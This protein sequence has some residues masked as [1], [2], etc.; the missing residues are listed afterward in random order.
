[1][2]LYIIKHTVDE[3]ELCNLE[4]KCLFKVSTDKNYFFV[5]DYIHVDRSPFV[6]FCIKDIIIHDSKEDL[7][8]YLISTNATYDGFKVKYMDIQGD[9]EFEKRHII[10]G[11]IGY[12]INGRVEVGNPSIVLGV[13]KLDGKWIFGQLEKN[14]GVW[15]IHMGR[16]QSY[17]NA[18]TTKTARAI[19]NISAQNNMELKIVDPCCGIGTVVMEAVSMGFDVKGYDI[20]EN[21]VAGAQKNLKFFKYPNVIQT[22]DIHK[23]EEFYDI[24][25]VDLP[26]GIL[27]IADVSTQQAIIERAAMLGRRLVVVSIIDMSQK[28]KDIHLKIVESCI[29]SKGNFKRHLYVCDK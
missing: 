8:R 14:S 23:L 20:N 6:K 22:M 4:K 21:I 17:C 25:I 19:V 5:E 18:L 29:I 2:N 16:P 27:S 9:V 1:M 12:N 15:Y 7:I 24:V 28:L 3:T 26:Y 10:E 13:T 11:E